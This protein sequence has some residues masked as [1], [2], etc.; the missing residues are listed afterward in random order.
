MMPHQK[1]WTKEEKEASRIKFMEGSRIR[2]E[3]MSWCVEVAR[4][5]RTECNNLTK[6]QRDE[7]LEKGMRMING[8]EHDSTSAEHHTDSRCVS[9]Q[10]APHP[11]PENQ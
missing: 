11:K 5:N 6:E 2:G 4:R 7:L 3:I 9:T 1:Q 10:I 8:Q